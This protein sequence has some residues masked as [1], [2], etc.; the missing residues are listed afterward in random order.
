M[1]QNIAKAERFGILDTGK[2]DSN[3]KPFNRFNVI[4]GWNGSGKTTLGRLLRCLETK[5][6]PETFK[7]G[8]FSITVEGHKVGSD[9]IEHSSNVRV[10]NQD[11]VTDNLDLFQARTKAII[12][13][14]SEKIKEKKEFD[15]K[16]LNLKLLNDQGD[17]LRIERDTLATRL[18]KCHQN[19]GKS[20][21]DFL[22]GTIYATVTYNKAT[23]INKIWPAIKSQN[24]QE[25]LLDE[26]SLIREKN[27]TLLNSS[28]VE[29]DES[30]LPLPIDVEKLSNIQLEVNDIIDKQIS[31]KVIE[32]LKGD[33]EVNEWVGQGFQIHRSRSSSSCEFCGALIKQERLK[34]LEQHFSDEYEDLMTS[35]LL[36]KGKLDKG[37]REEPQND[38]HLL[39]AELQKDYDAAIAQVK[40]LTISVNQQ[41]SKWISAVEQ[42]RANPFSAVSPTP[43]EKTIIDSYNLGIENL[44]AIIQK[45]NQQ[46]KSHGK[47]AEAAK[48]KIENHF[49]AQTAILDDML[50]IEQQQT[51]NADK[52]NLNNAEIKT[53]R[54][55]IQFLEAELKNDSIAIKEINEFLHKFLGRNEIEL[56]RLPAG[57]YELIRD[58]IPAKN[59]SEGEKTAISL[60]YFFSK[61]KEND[62]DVKNM[63]IIL[64]DPISS[65]DSNHLFNA[66]SFVK[67]YVENAKQTFVMT[68]NFWFFKQVRDWMIKK[69]EKKD[70]DGNPI[71][72]SHIYTIE[73]GGLKNAA[74]PLTRFHSEYQ[75]VFHTILSYR[76]V[77][78]MDD[79]SCFSVANASRRLLEAFTSFKT[80][81]NAGFNGALQLG[82]RNGLDPAKK[83]RI[84]YFL[85]KYSHLDRI[86]S[87]DNTVETLLE[88]G[89]NVVHDV[90]WLIKHTDSEHYNS[91]LKICGFEDKLV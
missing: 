82:E 70:E 32:R 41:I 83:E 53:V 36:L 85:N 91:M 12:F 80:P 46:S 37:I 63:I 10:F 86:E 3:L 38:G 67:K 13:I 25:L 22:L 48:S 26:S 1:I 61:I 29:Y 78:Y 69:N 40:L 81:D 11:F 66:S 35:C 9:K 33:T 44:R 57:G 20:I 4:Y 72:V 71:I 28:L 60:I 24:L 73:R 18:D 52:I 43:F 76:D 50:K 56:Q 58:N 49:V 68:H 7:E 75:H 84:H 2:F 34:E 54:E 51:V 55:R 17:K 21:K 16:K 15:E 39:Y 88:E 23:S 90:L 65:F 8:K 87:F 42:K 59:L 31:S 45:H 62:A 47:L 6:V 79:A 77:A 27:F 74:Q 64:D 30:H 19:A 5:T 89:K 14:S